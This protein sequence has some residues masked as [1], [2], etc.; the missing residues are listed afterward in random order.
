MQ[1]GKQMQVTGPRTTVVVPTPRSRPL[2]FPCFLYLD[3]SVSRGPVPNSLCLSH[4]PPAPGVLPMVSGTEWARTEGDTWRLLDSE[5]QPLPHPQLHAP[6]PPYH[7]KGRLEGHFKGHQCQSPASRETC[8]EETR[9][10]WQ[11]T[12]LGSSLSL[13]CSVALDKSPALC[14]NSLRLDREPL[15]IPSTS[16]SCPLAT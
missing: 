7:F 8:N 9:Q 2:A 13:A 15:G 16:A 14:Q 10:A 11:V 5:S 3:P 4:S 1:V 6:N 12:S